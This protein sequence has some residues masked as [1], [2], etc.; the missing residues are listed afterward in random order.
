[1]VQHRVNLNRDRVV[2]GSNEGHEVERE[3]LLGLFLKHHKNRTR[4]V[5]N[6]ITEIT[7][8][9]T[10]NNWEPQQP[11]HSASRVTNIWMEMFLT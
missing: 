10:T 11:Q 8:S 7:L 2:V 9:S 4:T 1:M 6:E 3:G 5:K